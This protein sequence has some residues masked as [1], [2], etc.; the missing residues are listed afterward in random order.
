MEA[1]KITISVT[2]DELTALYVAMTGALAHDI[3]K[4]QSDE[5]KRAAWG[6]MNKVEDKMENYGLLEDVVERN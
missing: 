1:R 5:L 2:E 6:I 4:D 3:Y